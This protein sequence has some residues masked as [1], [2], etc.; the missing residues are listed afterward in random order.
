MALPRGLELLLSPLPG[1]EVPE[2]TPDTRR[3]AITDAK[4]RRIGRPCTR[5]TFTTRPGRRTEILGEC[6]PSPKAVVQIAGKLKN[7]EAANGQKQT[8]NFTP[9]FSGEKPVHPK[10]ESK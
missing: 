4:I 5:R 9:K 2:R 6:P 3:R 8:L 10:T 1:C 7:L